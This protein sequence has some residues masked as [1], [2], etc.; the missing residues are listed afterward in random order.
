MATIRFRRLRVEDLPLIH[1]WLTNDPVVNHFWSYDKQE[2]FEDVV[3]EY[4]AY[5]NGDE[6]TDAYLVLHDEAPIGYV[7]TYF[8]RDYPGYEAYPELMSAASFDVFI[9]EASYRY[10]GLGPAL[11]T[12]FLREIV[13]ADPDVATCVIGPEER[14]T[15]AIRAYEKVGF[16]HVR[17][18]HDLPDEPWPVYLMT[19]GRE[20]IV[21]AATT[22]PAIA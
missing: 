6:P 11:L 15:S 3:K 1:H 4:S 13:F 17:T 8:W 18:V 2:S 20:Q 16:R 5:I 7:Q 19:I 12:Q 9:G 22:E 14:N 21:E 10:R